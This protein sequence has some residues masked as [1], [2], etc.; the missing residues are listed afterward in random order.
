MVELL[1]RTK[2]SASISVIKIRV[3]PSGIRS[4]AEISASDRQSRQNSKSLGTPG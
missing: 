2:P 3:T 1:D 4:T